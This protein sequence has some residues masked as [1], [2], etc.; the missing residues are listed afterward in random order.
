MVTEN[1]LGLVSGDSLLIIR[2]K[3]AG[4][5]ILVTCSFLVYRSVWETRVPYVGWYKPRLRQVDRKLKIHYKR[6]VV[7]MEALR[8]QGAVSII[9]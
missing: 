6:T 2:I 5:E 4:H 3:L 8:E 1:I 9:L 7:D